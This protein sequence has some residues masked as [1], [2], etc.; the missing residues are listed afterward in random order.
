MIILSTDFTGFWQVELLFK[1]VDLDPWKLSFWSTCNTFSLACQL[2]RDSNCIPRLDFPSTR[3][4]EYSFSL[5]PIA[6]GGEIWWLAYPRHVFS[7]SL[8]FQSLSICPIRFWGATAG[9]QH[10]FHSISWECM[11]IK[12]ADNSPD[13]S[14]R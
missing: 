10:P 12:L 2:L 6:P 7:Y 5:N 3:V 9:S 14:R 13:N 11:H 8:L 4:H 1:L